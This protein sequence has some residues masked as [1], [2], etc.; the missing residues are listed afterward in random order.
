MEVPNRS[1][2]TTI[3]IRSLIFIIRVQV[4]GKTITTTTSKRKSQYKS[5]TVDDIITTSLSAFSNSKISM[6]NPTGPTSS[7]ATKLG[8]PGP[9]GTKRRRMRSGGGNVSTQGANQPELHLED[10]DELSADGKTTQTTSCKG[11]TTIPL[12]LKSK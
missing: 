6:Q 9:I 11:V 12:F 1:P 3:L 5:T 10:L 7:L 8:F 4:C 2:F